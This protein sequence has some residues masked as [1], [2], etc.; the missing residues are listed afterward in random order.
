MRINI[1]ENIQLVHG[2][3]TILD[4]IRSVRLHGIFIPGTIS[5]QSVIVAP[6]ITAADGTV[7]ISFGLYSLNGTSSK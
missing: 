5:F 1:F 7:T 6:S 4:A 3:T 2:A